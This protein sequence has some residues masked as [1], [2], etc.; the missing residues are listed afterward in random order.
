MIRGYLHEYDDDLELAK[1]QY[2]KIMSIKPNFIDASLAYKSLGKKTKPKLRVRYSPPTVAHVPD[3]ELEEYINKLKEQYYSNDEVLHVL[4]KIQK[5]I[6]GKDEESLVRKEDDKRSR[7]ADELDFDQPD[8][9]ASTLIL[10]EKIEEQYQ[11][12]KG[13]VQD[14]KKE[15]WEQFG[16][17]LVTWGASEKEFFNK[18]PKSQFEKVRQGVYKE[19]FSVGNATHE[20]FVRFNKKGLWGINVYVTD[21]LSGNRDLYVHSLNNLT[22]ISGIGQNIGKTICE[23]NVELAVSLWQ[24]TDNYEVLVQELKDRDKVSMMRLSPKYLPDSEK[25]LCSVIPLLKNFKKV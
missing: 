18:Y 8:V 10:K 21:S 6:A 13:N 11:R 17:Y 4:N 3:K 1:E 22:K 12:S 20:Y 19:S 14:R 2:L 16:H 15:K 5:K 7:F 24:T 25:L 9:S 23:D